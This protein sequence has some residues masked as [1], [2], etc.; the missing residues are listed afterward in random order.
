M[1][2]NTC[3]SHLLKTQQ[4]PPGALIE[5]FYLFMKGNPLVS[6]DRIKAKVISKVFEWRQNNYLTVAIT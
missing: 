4:E 2:L 3:V 1:K 6:Q 5:F